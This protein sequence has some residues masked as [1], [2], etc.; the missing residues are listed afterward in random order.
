MKRIAIIALS[1]G[2]LLFTPA[3]AFARD[4]H[5]H[6]H[7]HHHH[8]WSDRGYGW[9]NYRSYRYDR[10][11]RDYWERRR[12]IEADRVANGYYPDGTPRPY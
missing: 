10:D 8:S 11:S 1:L 9:G 4:H 6:H 3:G 7:H 2:G 12:Q 5:H